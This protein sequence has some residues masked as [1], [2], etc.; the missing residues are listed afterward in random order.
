MTEALR[1]NAGAR[2]RDAFDLRWANCRATFHGRAY[3]TLAPTS[4][5]VRVSI[6]AITDI[7]GL[8]RSASDG[9][10]SSTIFTGMRCT[11]L[12]KLPVALSGGNSAN[13][14]PDAGDQLSTCPCKTLPGKASTVTRARWPARILVI[15]VSL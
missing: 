2:R 14:A 13:W 7:P 1:L 5:V 12:V 9:S 10:R 11:T 8:K 4:G 15:C 6:V 3:L